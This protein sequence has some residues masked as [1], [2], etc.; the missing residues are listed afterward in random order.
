MLIIST[1]H[2]ICLTLCSVSIK[3]GGLTELNRPWNPASTKHFLFDKVFC[4][5]FTERHVL[6]QFLVPCSSLTAVSLWLNLIHKQ[7]GG[8]W[9]RSASFCPA[10]TLGW[11]HTWQTMPPCPTET[12]GVGWRRHLSPGQLNAPSHMLLPGHPTPSSWPC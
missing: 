4:F 10:D 11:S 1:A 9:D 6:L 8:S 5:F 12:P 3:I 7:L 2:F